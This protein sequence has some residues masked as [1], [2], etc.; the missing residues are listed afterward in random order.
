MLRTVSLT[1]GTIIAIAGFILALV[2]MLLYTRADTFKKIF[3]CETG[4]SLAL[5]GQDGNLANGAAECAPSRK[6]DG[7][8]YFVSCGGLF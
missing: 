5:R 3:A 2:G 4:F 6:A 8:I 7:K 1:R